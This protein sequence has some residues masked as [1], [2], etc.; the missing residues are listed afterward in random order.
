MLQW[1]ENLV[2]HELDIHRIL[3][4]RPLITELGKPSPSASGQPTRL[5]AHQ[6]SLKRSGWDN[7]V[8][9][10]AWGRSY[11]GERAV[12]FTSIPDQKFEPAISFH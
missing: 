5:P 1:E 12:S 11:S 6:G 2:K 9:S 10:K 3:V 7:N 4:S 8:S